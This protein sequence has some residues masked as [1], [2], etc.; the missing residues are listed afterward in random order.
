[1]VELNAHAAGNG[2]QMPRDAYSLP[3]LPLGGSEAI[4]IIHAEGVIA[5]QNDCLH[6][7]P[8]N[9]CNLPASKALPGSDGNE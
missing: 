4:I 2:G 3:S 8:G 5:G 6:Y 9:R 7:D 1:M